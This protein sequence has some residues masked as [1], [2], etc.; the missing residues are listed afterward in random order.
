MIGHYIINK[1]MLARR[2][3]YE[4]TEANDRKAGFNECFDDYYN[5]W[6][7]TP[8]EL[9]VEEAHIKGEYITNPSDTGARKKVAVICHGLTATKLATIKYGAIFY[10][11]GF[12]LVIFD[13]RYFGESTGKYC[14][15][16]MREAEDVKKITAFA[17]SIF[18]ED[19]IM[20]L[21]GE[22]MG[23]GTVLK[24]LDTEK[25]DFVVADCPFADTGLLIDTLARERAWLLGIPAAGIARK[26]GIKRCGYDFRAIRPIESVES[27]DVPIL[28]MHGEADS[29]I[30]C[31]HSVQMHKKC[32]NPLSE[33]HLFK[34]AEH[35]L[36][37]ASDPEGYEKYMTAFINRC[38]EEGK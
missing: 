38:L 18:G 27:T 26:V 8:F 37:I 36:S 16:G 21:H 11:L 28:F 4:E 10:R 13:E 7:K 9:D 6:E 14:T 25:P 24:L 12:N 30:N 23:G 22:S 1:I 33:I 20:G 29:L 2:M 15:L 5:K 35:A 3:T 34:G 31:N 17:R 19:C 32:R